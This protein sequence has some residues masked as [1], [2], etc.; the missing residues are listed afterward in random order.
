MVYAV[1]AYRGTVLL[2]FYILYDHRIAA[3]SGLARSCSVHGLWCPPTGCPRD[4]REWSLRYCADSPPGVVPAGIVYYGIGPGVAAYVLDW[5]TDQ[6]IGIRSDPERIA[7]FKKQ[8]AVSATW[9]IAG[10][11]K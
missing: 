1:V 11:L 4:L 9:S 7:A 2:I 3:G 10:V 6:P 8:F 5:N